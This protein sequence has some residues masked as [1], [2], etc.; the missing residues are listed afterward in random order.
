M[1][2]PMERRLTELIRLTQACACF[3]S[4]TLQCAIHIFVRILGLPE[5]RESV[6]GRTFL[7]DHNGDFYFSLLGLELLQRG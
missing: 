4:L 2:R 5:L 1:R 3:G 6:T 7:A